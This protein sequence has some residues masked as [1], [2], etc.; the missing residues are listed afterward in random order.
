MWEVEY[1]DEFDDWYQSLTEQDQDAVI[2]RVELLE[3]AGPGL[4]RPVAD[5][6]HQSRH[7]NMKEL[8]A[9]RAIRALFAFDPR[10]T[11][12]LLIGGHKSPDGPESPNWNQWYDHYLPIADAL[13]DT[14]LDELRQEGLI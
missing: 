8:R 9:E 4:G 3:S 5:N 7:P 6:V 12:I 11:A 10:R 14:H 1:T 2:A 13:Y